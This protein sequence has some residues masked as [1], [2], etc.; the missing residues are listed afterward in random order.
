M[1]TLLL[2]VVIAVPFLIAAQ[3]LLEPHW[4]RVREITFAHPDVPAAFH[5]VRIALVTDIHHGPTFSR[6]RVRHTVDFTNRL[7]PDLIV[8]AGDYVYKGARFIAPCF[9][10]LARLQAPLG[11]YG[12]LGNHDHWM[13]ARESSEAMMAAG[14]GWLVNQAVWLE[15][16]G[17]R[18]RLGGVDDLWE[19]VQRPGATTAEALDGDLVIL[20]SHHPDYA[21]ELNDPRVDLML[22]GHTHGGQVTFFGKWA[23]LVPSRFGQRYRS[24]VVQVGSLTVVVSHGV[25]TINPPVRFFARPEIVVITLARAG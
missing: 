13:G 25:G 7:A 4:L 23:P 10:E 2:A 14:I 6:Q 18:I 19:G 16:D 9:E 3:M 5:G 1:L 8:L 21:E 15:R 12:V 20:L 24:G 17:A 22:S 11:V